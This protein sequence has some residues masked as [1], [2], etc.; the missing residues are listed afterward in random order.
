M[1]D[2]ASSWFR[3]AVVAGVALVGLAYANHWSN[4]FHF[5]DEHT[6]VQNLAIRRLS[7][8]P[9]L[10]TDASAASV[11]PT[12]AVHRP[13]TYVTLAVDH[14][15]A[16]G[17]KPPF[18]H[19]STFVALLLLLWAI[20]VLARCVLDAS[21]PHPYN[22][23]L[24]L[25]GA[26]L[27]GVHPAGA[28]TVN[29]IIQRAEVWS[30]LGTTAAVS[31]YA[32][33]P[34]WR[35]Y[36]AFI[37]FGV[38]GI[39]AKT[40]ASIFPIL[41]G[42]YGLLIDRGARRER[43]ASF[44]ASLG[45]GAAATAVVG[46][47]TYSTQT[48]DPGAPPFWQYLWTQPW[49]ILRYFRNFFLPIDLSI[50]PG[51]A[52]LA[53]PTE[54]RAIAGLLGLAALLIF[55]VR[56]ARHRETAGISFGIAWFLI[57]L[58]PASVFPLA[59]VTND[60]RMFLPFV[61]LCV[62]AAAAARMVVV[63]DWIRP[64]VWAASGVAVLVVA[65]IGTWQRNA[66]W[67]SHE[68]VWADAVRKNPEHG[69]ARMNL[70][71]ALMGRGALEEARVQF[72]E[73]TRFTPNYSVLE[74]NLGVVNDSLG[75]RAEAEAHFQRALALSPASAVPHFYY[76]RWLLAQQRTAEAVAYLE[77]AVAIGPDD[78]ESRRLL[79][80]ALRAHR[81][82][83]RLQ[84]LA[85]ETLRRAP[86]DAGAQAALVEAQAGLGELARL[87]AAV[88]AAPTAEGWLDL[89][90]RLYNERDFAGSIDA[91][92]AALAIRADYAEA[93]NNIAAAHSALGQWAEA[94]AAAQRALAIKPDFPLARN[95]LSWALAQQAK[96]KK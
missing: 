93:Y 5:D 66:A 30:A 55:C 88:Q 25:G 43:W 35:R 81:D 32:A 21:A 96:P 68:T 26:V 8:L 47:R 69:R 9:R 10:L 74:V 49:V 73:A 44:I 6:V 17:L 11:Y 4:P 72:E 67:S 77:R 40:S 19:A 75:R 7:N 83:R 76:G 52:P 14:A 13:V 71:V 91:A 65:A 27:F 70:G 90:L 42:L 51:W 34:A 3:L 29:Y 23:W 45:A 38:L 54:P 12:H 94:V 36:G 31:L 62:S 41:I 22:A 63:R 20:Y 37:A 58:V 53:S 2:R 46:I 16:G 57:A 64:R 86:G 33:R 84:E 79:A 82:F 15:L 48:F 95:N 85:A 87:R 24:A 80:E 39:F 1:A 60:H 28:D 18:F 78:L 92:R 50:D 59:E 56:F 61:G 89:S